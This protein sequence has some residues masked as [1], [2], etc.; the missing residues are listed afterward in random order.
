MEE[1]L[2]EQNTLH[3]IQEANKHIIFKIIRARLLSGEELYPHRRLV[4]QQFERSLF[5]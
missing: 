4:E 1:E 2:G 3:D 5:S